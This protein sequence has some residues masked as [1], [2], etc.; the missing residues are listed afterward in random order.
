M[1]ISKELL[2]ELLSVVARPEDLLGDKG[3]MKELKIRLMEQMFGAEL[4]EQPGYEP[5]GEP[6]GHSR[7]RDRADRRSSHPC[8]KIPCPGL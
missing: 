2:G 5:H 6:S 1:T 3:L 8:R 4:T 7:P